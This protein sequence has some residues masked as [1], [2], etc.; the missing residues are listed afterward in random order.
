MFE[1]LTN[2][3]NDE[4]FNQLEKKLVYYKQQSERSVHYG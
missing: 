2:Q 3:T 4:T 1:T